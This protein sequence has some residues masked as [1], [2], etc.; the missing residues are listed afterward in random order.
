MSDGARRHPAGRI[1]LATGAL[2]LAGAVLAPAALAPPTPASQ[3]PTPRVCLPD[4]A[5]ILTSRGTFDLPS[6]SQLCY[7]AHPAEAA[8]GGLVID[9]VAV[10]RSPLILREGETVRFTFAAAPESVVTLTATAPNG[11]R[12]GPVYR[13]SPYT[14]TWRV[15]PGQ[16]TI[17]VSTTQWLLTESVG[18]APHIETVRYHAPYR[19]VARR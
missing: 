16:G 14:T 5:K 2:A 18:L 7:V 11:A 4:A 10:R 19:T 1:L 15:R 6:L 13:L 3:V 8:P 12:R 17:V 9:R